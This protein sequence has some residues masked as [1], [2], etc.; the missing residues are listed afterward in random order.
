MLSIPLSRIY[1]AELAVS[2]SADEP[3]RIPA[4]EET[5]HAYFSILK[6]GHWRQNIGLPFED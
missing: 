6:R 3:A 1:G 5:I 2:I 4:L